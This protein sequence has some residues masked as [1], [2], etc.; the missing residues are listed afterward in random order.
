M[1]IKKS[2][3]TGLVQQIETAKKN[4][5]GNCLI[6][7]RCLSEI[8]TNDL[9]KPY[10]DHLETF[11]DFLKEIVIPKSTG[12]HYMRIW[13]KFGEYLSAN[14]LAIPTRRL[15]KLLPIA[16]EE[17]KEELL[18]KAEILNEVDF[19]K[20]LQEEKGIIDCKCPEEARQYFY[21][22]KI[23]KKWTKIEKPISDLED[24]RNAFG[25]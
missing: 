18:H 20:E 10:G 23:C 17:N 24:N 3:I 9:W 21:Q 6:I 1:E 19:N 2:D 15:I 5:V 16:T 13:D 14:G 7:G 8:A 12:H 4:M 11:D 22:C 25:N